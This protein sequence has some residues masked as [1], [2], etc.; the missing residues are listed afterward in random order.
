MSASALSG[1]PSHSA[2]KLPRSQPALWLGHA[3]RQA[4]AAAEAPA[5]SPRAMRAPISNSNS[6]KVGVAIEAA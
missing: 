2:A 4:W 3:A 5:K 6:A 1:L